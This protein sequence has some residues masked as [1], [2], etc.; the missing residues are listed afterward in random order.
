MPQQG[1]AVITGFVGSDPGSLGREGGPAACSFRLGCTRR[2]F[3]AQQRQWR[4][5]P[6][7]WIT[8]KSFRQ[9]AVNVMT[10]V[11]KGD[12]V[13]VTG[14]LA[15]DEWTKDGI[16][17]TSIVMHASCVGHDLSRGTS[18]FVKSPLPAQT[19]DGLG[20]E[21]FE[22][23]EREDGDGDEHVHENA[24]RGDESSDS[25][26]DATGDAAAAHRAR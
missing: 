17:R 16:N 24:T 11:R 26:E 2:F 14:S 18:T 12:P 3:D 21:E 20:G 10:S 25:S 4:D 7:V 13:I 23:D 6:T 8:V 19:E 1:I 22:E 5:H 9:L 15:Q